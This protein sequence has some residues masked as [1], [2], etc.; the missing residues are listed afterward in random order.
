MASL[1]KAKRTTLKP[2]MDAALALAFQLHGNDTRK[3]SQV[4][5]MTHLLNVCALVIQD[6][7]DEDEAIAALLHDALEDK[8]A[9]I[10]LDEIKQR[11]GDRVATIVALCSDTPE[12]FRGG[13][14]GPWKERKNRYL[15]KIRSHDP[16]LLRVTVADK[17]DNA[18][19]I[20]ADHRRIGDDLWGRFNAGK[21]EQKW[22][23]GEA[24]R[25]YRQAGFSGSLLEEL[26]RLVSAMDAL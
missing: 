9:E 16:D 22:Y 21:D 26:E 1:S 11:F 23:Y 17:I 25:E 13:E 2:R 14:K 12:D 18:R 7:G 3:C 5:Y 15:S 20:L 10:S 24:L 6:G 19:A 4:P 8:P